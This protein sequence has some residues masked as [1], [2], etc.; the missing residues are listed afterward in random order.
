[1]KKKHIRIAVDVIMTVLLLML[2]AYSLIGE[3]LHEIIGTAIF[4]LY[5]A[6]HII[7]HGFYKAFFI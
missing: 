3:N 6:H 2:M 4:V 7:N 5:I 1:M